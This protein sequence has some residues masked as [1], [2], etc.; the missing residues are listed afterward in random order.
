MFD[1]TDLIMASEPRGESLVKDADAV[2]Q[3]AHAFERLKR[4]DTR[5]IA[6][7]L[8]KNAPREYKRSKYAVKN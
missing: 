8:V 3:M 5:E 2:R 4:G 1:F 7:R 6:R